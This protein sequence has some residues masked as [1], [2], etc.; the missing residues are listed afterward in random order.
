MAEPNSCPAEVTKDLYGFSLTN[1]STAQQSE[2]ILCDAMARKAEAAWRPF[3]ERQK[4]PT[5][6]RLKEL[7]R[8]GV[9]PVMRPWVWMETSGAA[10]R[11]D[12]A[13]KSYF[14]N[15]VFTQPNPKWLAELEKDLPHTFPHHSWLQSADGQLAMRRVLAAYSVHNPQVGYCRGMNCIVGF[16]LVTLNRNEEKAFWLLA[17]LIENIL[18]PGLY[19]G[20]LEGCQLEMKALE[21]LIAE[22]LPRLADHFIGL[23]TDVSVVATDWFLC[24]FTISLPSETVARVFDCI[25]NEGPKVTFRVGLA[26]LKSLESQIRDTKETGNMVFLI[27]KGASG[28]HNRDKLM[29]LAFNGIGSLSMNDIDFYRG[30]KLEEVQERVWGRR[31]SGQNG[32]SGGP[33]SPRKESGVANPEGGLRARPEGAGAAGLKKGFGMFMDATKALHAKTVAAINKEGGSESPR[34]RGAGPAGAGRGGKVPCE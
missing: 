33:G 24:L 3:L 23:D 29:D 15:I 31:V 6:K 16:L 7:I 11:K 2:R 9:P 22:K 30:V 28:M 25:F 20:S 21:M 34:T 18:F 10:A 8:E 4:L 12:K 14:Q 1:L 32:N 13:D 19:G 17:T 26:V 5:D 27:K